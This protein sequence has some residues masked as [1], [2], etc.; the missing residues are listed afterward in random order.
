[1]FFILGHYGCP[2]GFLP[3]L[4]MGQRDIS[5]K[6]RYSAHI[7]LNNFRVQ[8]FKI[9]GREDFEKKDFFVTYEMRKMTTSLSETAFPSVKVWSVLDLMKSWH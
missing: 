3:N 2:G 4:G 8:N 6:L 7:F 9:W 5:F 1:M